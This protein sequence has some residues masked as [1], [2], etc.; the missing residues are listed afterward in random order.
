MGGLGVRFEIRDL[1]MMGELR[2]MVDFRVMGLR[3]GMFMLVIL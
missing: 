2:M 3:L 1:R